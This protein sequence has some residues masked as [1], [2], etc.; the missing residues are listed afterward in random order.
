MY[1]H[2]LTLDILALELGASDLG[3][4]QNFGSAQELDLALSI[5]K[6]SSEDSATAV[7]NL[8]TAAV[9]EGSC[10]AAKLKSIENGKMSDK[11]STEHGANHSTAQVLHPESYPN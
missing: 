2:I 4:G 10:L 3:L 7:L 11:F 8:F 5:M 6:L 9:L 1:H